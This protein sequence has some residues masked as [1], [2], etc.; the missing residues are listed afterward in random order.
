MSCLRFYLHEGILS[1]DTYCIPI[2]YGFR[3]STNNNRIRRS[4]IL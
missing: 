1:R 4:S 2:L 3:S